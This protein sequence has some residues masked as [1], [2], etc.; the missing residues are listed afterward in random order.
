MLL[1]I[2]AIIVVVNSLDY[3]LFGNR[4]VYENLVRGID[5]III[6]DLIKEI[7]NPR[8]SWEYV[9]MLFLYPLL[10]LIASVCFIVSFILHP[11]SHL[12][13]FVYKKLR[14]SQPSA[15]KLPT[16]Y[17]MNVAPVYVKLKAKELAFAPKT[18][19]V[20]Y[21]SPIPNPDFDK[22]ISDNLEEIKAICALYKLEFIYLPDFNKQF[23]SS[24]LSS[25]ITYANPR[26]RGVSNRV[27]NILTYE[28]LAEY[29]HIPDTIVSPSLVR[30]RYVECSNC[31]FSIKQLENVDF[32]VF[33]LELHSYLD[34]CGGS[35]ALYSLITDEKMRLYLSQF[36]ADDRFREDIILIGKE[37][38]Q[39][40]EK[41]K[42][43]GLTS[44]A[45]KKLISDVEMQPSRLVVD[46]QKRIV[47]TDYDNMEVKLSPIHK[48]VF[49]LFLRHPEGIYFKELYGYK[50]ELTN[51]YMSIT[52][53]AS[54]A[55]INDSL[56]RL[57]DPL[58]NSINEKCARIKNAFVSE[59]SE[60]IAAWYIIDGEKGKQKKIKLPRE[61]VEWK[62]DL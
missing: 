41:L 18:K 46:K 15:E 27:S 57:T 13:T 60:D 32:S 44:I 1:I 52:G 51:L 2:L 10:F 36:E 14:K 26:A 62:C 42:T 38:K 53:R 48:A 58:D 31:E 9:A 20:I 34:K 29:I 6:D 55:A 30:C 21:Y 16:D 45:I 28:M 39:R 47:L 25:L 50:T 7:L 56:E 24:D 4:E 37:I 23:E 40:V 35:G 43:Y 17:V 5:E 22:M 11:Y 54:L 59:F 61:M 12:C 49:F 8:W 33:K 3:F 19:E